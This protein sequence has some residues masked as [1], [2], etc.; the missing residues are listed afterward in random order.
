MNNNEIFSIFPGNNSMD[1]CVL[2]DRLKDDLVVVS[3]TQTGGPFDGGVVAVNVPVYTAK[4]LST[5]ILCNE[6]SEIAEVRRGLYDFVLE[7][8]RLPV[9]EFTSEEGSIRIY[10]CTATTWTVVLTN[11][12]LEM[13]V[14]LRHNEFRRW[15][16]G[17][18]FAVSAWT[19]NRYASFCT[20]PA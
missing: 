13:S 20:R 14:T 16:H 10:P 1:F 12:N 9:Y 8:K 19:A 11:E 18:E 7:N 2:A 3:C 6:L 17:L 4:D 5:A 15:G